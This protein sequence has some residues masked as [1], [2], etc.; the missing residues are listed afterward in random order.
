MEKRLALSLGTAALALSLV[1]NGALAEDKKVVSKKL[2]ENDK[3]IVVENTYAPGAVSDMTRS[4]MRVVHVLKGGT[5]ERT[6][7]DGK[8]EK[9]AVKKGETR[10]N[11]PGPAYVNKNVGKSDIVLYV[12]RLK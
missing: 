3:V 10:I 5:F 8:K 4:Q 11:E 9:V 7:A 1:A 2:A 6:Y 12:V